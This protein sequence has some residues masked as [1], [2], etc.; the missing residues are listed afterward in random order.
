MKHFTLSE[1]KCSC[2]DTE[3]MQREFLNQLDLA[4]EIAGVPF[5][6]TSGYRCP[7]HNK[8]VGGVQ[9]SSHTKGLAADIA[10]VNGPRRYK[11]IV[12]L[13]NAGFT[14]IGVHRK[15]IHVDADHSKSQQVI[16]MY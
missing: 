10:C 6:I 13:L 4:R 8:A 12:A 11:I 1:F 3:E 7:E 9:D 14:R 15:F 5:K 16:W 2:C